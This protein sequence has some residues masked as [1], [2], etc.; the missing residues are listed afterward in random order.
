MQAVGVPPDHLKYREHW[1]S[2]ASTATLSEDDTKERIHSVIQRL[3]SS[4][5]LPDTAEGI[6]TLTHLRTDDDQSSI[7]AWLGTAAQG[8]AV[9]WATPPPPAAKAAAD[10]W[11]NAQVAPAAAPTTLP[12]AQAPAP[13][14]PAPGG[15]IAPPGIPNSSPLPTQHSLAQPPLPD[16]TQGGDALPPVPAGASAPTQQESAGANALSD[17]PQ[18]LYQ[19]PGAQQYQP[20]QQ[21][22]YGQQ[23][24]GAQQA[25]YQQAYMPG[26]AAPQHGTA[27]VPQQ[28]LP[29]QQAYQQPQQMQAG[30][31]GLPMPQ[32]GQQQY[33]PQTSYVPQGQL[34][35]PAAYG[36][37]AGYGTSPVP[38]AQL[39]APGSS[40]AAAGPPG[41]GAASPTQPQQLQQPPAPT[42]QPQMPGMPQYA[43]SI[44]YQ[45]AAP[46]GYT[47][48]PQYGSGTLPGMQAGQGFVQQPGQMPV[49]PQVG[50]P[51]Q[52]GAI[53]QQ[54]LQPQVQ[55]PGMQQAPYQVQP[56]QQ[57]MAMG[58][59]QGSQVYGPANP[60]GTAVQQ[61]GSGALH[62]Q[63]AP[64]S[65][66]QQSPTPVH[67]NPESRFASDMSGSTGYDAYGGGG[68]SQGAP[69]QMGQGGHHRSALGAR[70]ALPRSW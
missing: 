54:Q 14:A 12:P 60:Y 7:L 34:Q 66:G 69:R 45:Q 17:Q 23:P 68:S 43:H 62:G 26:M 20:T 37:P 4:F 52:Y 33:A 22:P 28:Q 56:Q 70:G 59:P 47:A 49:Q 51:A 42:Q 18:A 31:P 35:P 15:G 53:G 6:E 3:D 10:A 25:P 27:A 29:Q 57:S 38:Q 50:A 65:A 2:P 39:Q 24:Y 67:A 1:M 41:I 58:A 44:A 13:T 64:A 55:Y 61:A 40:G 32:Q 8:K 9:G 30:A 19:G 11:Y 46:M 63:Y 21:Q 48:Q 5:E 36:S 16:G